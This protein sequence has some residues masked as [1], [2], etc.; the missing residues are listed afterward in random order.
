MTEATPRTVDKGALLPALLNTSKNNATMVQKAKSLEL[1]VKAG[2]MYE[3]DFAGGK[4]FRLGATFDGEA[5]PL[6]I[7]MRLYRTTKGVLVA[8]PE[9][10]AI[11]KG[12]GSPFP[13]YATHLWHG[14]PGNAQEPAQAIAVSIPIMSGSQI[15]VA[16]NSLIAAC[17]DKETGAIAYEAM[18]EAGIIYTRELQ[19]GDQVRQVEA[20]ARPY[21]DL[22]DPELGLLGDVRGNKDGKVTFIVNPQDQ[23]GRLCWGERPGYGVWE[24][25]REGTA[26]HRIEGQPGSNAVVPILQKAFDKA[27]ELSGKTGEL[28]NEFKREERKSLAERFFEKQTDAQAATQGQENRQTQ[29]V[30]AL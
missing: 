2:R 11:P 1:P 4:L 24:S 29:V 13:G 22:G 20:I 25:D 9:W 5:V 23:N 27:R 3:S 26:V 14:N 15:Q 16:F 10:T 6:H 7:S 21:K 8:C 19:R 12:G 30:P 17:N 28:K 18:R